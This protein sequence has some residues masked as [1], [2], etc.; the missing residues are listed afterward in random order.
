M[1]I[2]QQI[3]DASPNLSHLVVSWKDFH[4]CSKTYSNLK[5]LHLLLD[6]L[7][8][9]PKQHVNVHR[10]YQLSPHLCQLETSLA[11]IMFNENL[12]EFVLEIIRQFH[13][14]VYLI[15]NKASLYS[16]KEEKKLIFKERLIE[17]GNG[18]LFD[19][20]NIRIRFPSCDELH[21]WL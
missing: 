21:I 13:Q 19:A 10:L 3:L 9:E 14:L 16:S 17:A 4:R 6:R 12:L 1:T 15:L 20:N 7:Y 18:R 2:V 11:N 5:H 8:P